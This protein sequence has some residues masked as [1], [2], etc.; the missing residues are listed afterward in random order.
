MIEATTPSPATLALFA[1][2]TGAGTPD[3]APVSQGA[4]APKFGVTPAGNPASGVSAFGVSTSVTAPMPAA[5]GVP[6]RAA[7]GVYANPALTTGT[8]GRGAAT[9]IDGQLSFGRGVTEARGAATAQAVAGHS[10]AA[11]SPVQAA[12]GY[13]RAGAAAVPR[14]TP[15]LDASA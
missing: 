15:F 1:A 13:A 9:R 3:P 11:A 12:A 8:P 4:T 14:A 5:S 2:R 7:M 6:D 10:Q